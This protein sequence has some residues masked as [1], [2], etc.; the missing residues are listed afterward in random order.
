M[1]LTVLLVSCIVEKPW[2]I[3][4]RSAYFASVWTSFL[5]LGAITVGAILA[6]LMLMSEFNVIVLTSAMTFQVAGARPAHR[7]L[8]MV[9]WTL[10]SAS[11]SR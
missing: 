2:D 9:P 8:T 5:T 10:N 4:P 1:S 7:F 6:F 11:N 3:L